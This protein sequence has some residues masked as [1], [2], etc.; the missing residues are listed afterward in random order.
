MVWGIISQLLT[1]AAPIREHRCTPSR[2]RKR[3]VSG[4]A[5]TVIALCEPH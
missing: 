2:D 5:E 4:F 3:A 1:V